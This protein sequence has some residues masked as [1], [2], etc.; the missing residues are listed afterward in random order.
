MITLYF[1]SIP[2]GSDALSGPTGHSVSRQATYAQYD[3][4]RGKPVL[5][6]VGT[7]L[8]T[9][10]FDFYF[11]EEFC[12]PQSELNKLELAFSM[13]TPLPLLFA[14]GGF[15]GQRYVVDRLDITVQKSNRSGAIVRVDATI[16]LLEAPVVSLLSLVKSIA[17]AVAP[18]LTQ[19]AGTNPNVRR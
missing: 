15:T 11:S 9:Q 10:T 19:S 16:T 4:T 7:E 13:K 1:G 14:A 2:M 12:D 18:A 17:R 8:D 3:V 5:H 6:D